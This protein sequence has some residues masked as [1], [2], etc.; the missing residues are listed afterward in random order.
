[1]MDNHRYDLQ[2]LKQGAEWII[3]V[4]EVG[5]GP[6]AGP[7]T[8]C[9]VAINPVAL[10]AITQKPWSSRVTDSK[11]LNETDRNELAHEFQAFAAD[12]A[13]PV[14]I[15]SVAPSVIDEINIL[16]AT[17]LAMRQ[18]LDSIENKSVLPELPRANPDKLTLAAE[19]QLSGR[20]AVLV[21]GLPLK[22]FPYEHRALVKGDSRSLVIGLASIL[23]KVDRDQYMADLSKKYPQYLWEQNKGYG[24]VK[25]RKAIQESGVTKEH[26]KSFLRNIL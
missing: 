18:C 5:R 7:V 24:T 22:G 16:E 4:D 1:M 10:M 8:A 6:L 13:L 26:R 17:K 23:A 14:S 21:D 12:Y 3:G 20:V 11:K 25:H 9:A 15:R 2:V 19:D